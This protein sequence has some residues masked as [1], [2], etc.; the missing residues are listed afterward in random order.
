[1]KN[2]ILVSHNGMGDNLFMIGALRFLLKF[3]QKIQFLCKNKYL[4][5]IELF[6]SDE[7]R[8]I[9][10]GFD[11]NHEFREIKRILKK[12]LKKKDILTCGE[13]N[14]TFRPMISNRKFLEYRTDIER[15]NLDYDQI[16]SQNYAP[17]KN[18]YTDINLNLNHFFEYFKLP[19]TEES[20]KL[21]ENVKDYYLIF[22]QSTCS[23]GRKL[24]LENVME[25]Y[26]NDEK[27]LLIC[28][29]E[30]LYD[31]DHKKY[32]IANEFVLRNIIDLVEIIKQ[33]DE[34][35]IIDSCFTGIVLPY[36]KTNRLKAT[37]VKITLRT[38][39]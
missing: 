12:E 2:A 8:I 37:K 30:N 1:M 14:K 25:K 34:I 33:S 32:E 39:V 6:F 20:K 9:C 3:Y 23:D 18:F 29:D 4:K 31:K 11:E 19:E 26:L 21:Y 28:N 15:Y 22:I 16:N 24:N 10:R 5:N 27:S 38:N 17:I 13:F 35:Y 7:S 36:L